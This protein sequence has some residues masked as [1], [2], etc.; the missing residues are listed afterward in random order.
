VLL[1]IDVETLSE[2]DLKKVGL[3]AY[4]AHPSTKIIML[5]YATDD[6]PVQQWQAHQGPMPDDLQAMLLN[7]AI[8]KIG[9]N[10][11]FERA[12][13]AS[14]L[15]IV[16]PLK[17][18]F[19][20]MCHSR[21][22]G[23]PG[24]LD[25]ASRV[26]G[27]GDAGKMKEGKQLMKLFSI[28]TKAT[29]KKPAH[30]KNHETNPVEWE[31]YL[32]YNRQDVS[33]ERACAHRLNEIG[34]FPASEYQVW[35]LDQL[36]NNRGLTLDE[37][38]IANARRLTK[39]EVEEIVQKIKAITSVANPN[40]GQ[41]MR[42]WF[43]AQSYAMKSLDKPHVEAA[44]NDAKLPAPCRE[45]FLLKQRQGGSASSKLVS[46]AER[47]HGGRLQGQFVYFGAHTGRWASWGVNI[48]NLLRPTPR[49]KKLTAEITNAIL[50]GD[51]LGML[52]IPVVEAVSGV[53]RSCFRAPSGSRYLISDLA[54]VENRVLSW[55]SNCVNM[56]KIYEDGRCAYKTFACL[57]YNKLYDEIT[58]DERQRAKAPVLGCG[59]GMG[60]K[61]LAA[62]A[63]NMGIDMSEEE[64]QVYV[65]LFRA[66]YPE[67]PDFWYN[68]GA[69]AMQAVQDF[70]V[71]RLGKLRIDGSQPEML[72]IILPSGRALHYVKPMVIEDPDWAGKS[73]LVYEGMGKA[74]GVVKTRG[75][76]IVE[77]VVQA[78]SR[79]LL[80]NAMMR[81]H[82]LG[83]PLVLHCHDELV[84]QLAHSSPLTLEGFNSCMTD[85][86][87]WATGLPIGAEGFESEFYRKN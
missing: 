74:W 22:L 77:N 7:P 5:A 19:D 48:Q 3:A 64:A 78:A 44:L 6:G 83:Y 11:T 50:C 86:P 28:L 71:L 30:F 49:V 29:E 69:A 8:T 80:V 10:V 24:A 60:S 45:V 25:A 52:G 72:R 47:A 18:C 84:A 38:F 36:I 14:T 56:L 27:L 31:T 13:L 39:G 57:M 70:C 79:D 41:Q 16:L 58:A 2:A 66:T 43:A 59:F 54:Q 55:F 51:D 62:Y 40:S 12:L 21:Y 35:I 23:Y 37:T 46:I 82:K 26:L 65:E 1:H 76:K 9:W 61:R 34:E 32:Q 87:A 17:S 20:T 68:L 85:V 15:G 53:L 73:I 67:I 81:A 33:A 75:A 63:R 42:K 4:A